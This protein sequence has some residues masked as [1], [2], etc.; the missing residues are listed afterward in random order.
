MISEQEH[1]YFRCIAVK[2]MQS[3]YDALP[4]E[5]SVGKFGVLAGEPSPSLPQTFPRKCTSRGALDFSFHRISTSDS[6]IPRFPS[7][8]R[9][10]LH[11]SGSV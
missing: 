9:L 7:G 4:T 2:L 1:C 11:Y 6:Q 8:F 3:G 10:R 5:K